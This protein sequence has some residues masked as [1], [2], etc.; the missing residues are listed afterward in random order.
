VRRLNL[1]YAIITSV[2][3]DD[4]DDGGARHF[5]LTVA[6]VR[7]GVPDVRVEVLVPDFAGKR[8]SATVVFDCAPDVFA[9]NLETV[10][11]L[12]ARVRPGADYRRSL[13]LLAAAKDYGLITKSGIMLGLGERESEVLS[14]MD[15]LRYAG[16]DML[17][18]GQYLSPS[19]TNLP[20]TECVPLERFEKY[21]RTAISK[22]FR[23]CASAPYVRSSYS[24]ESAVLSI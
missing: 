22:G 21:H 10:P 19:K 4:I 5:V 14:V 20:V 23:H 3:R 13:S 6:A 16:C 12:Y 2:T 15:D 7:A 1:K 11:R 18:L 8:A 17:T 24:A 9:H